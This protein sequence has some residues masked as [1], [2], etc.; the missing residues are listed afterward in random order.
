HPA[1][2]QHGGH[3]GILAAGLQQGAEHRDPA[4]EA[5]GAAVLGVAGGAA[6]GLLEGDPVGVSGTCD[7]IE[8]VEPFS[9]RGS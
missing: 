8:T 7:Q 1:G 6:G 4:E 2:D 9:R 3:A 5:E